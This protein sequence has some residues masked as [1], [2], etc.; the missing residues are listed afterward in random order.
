MTV[1]L[2][3]ALDRIRARAEGDPEFA[4]A[5]RAM[6]DDG[7]VDPFAPPGAAVVQAA[8]SVNRRRQ[9]TRDAAL[10]DLSFTTPQVVDL[11]V[12]VAD[13]KGVDRRRRRGSLIGIRSGRDTLHP[14]WQF[15]PRRRDTWVGLAQV[16]AALRSVS[17]DAIELHAIATAPGASV[18]GRSI[19]ELLAAGEVDGAVSAA[20]MAGDQS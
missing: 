12:S 15:D 7:V 6:A 14:A 19:A 5:V 13:R 11:L 8:R 4:S 9:A 17:E 16:V 2:D 18:D 10:R 1:T 3:A 20:R